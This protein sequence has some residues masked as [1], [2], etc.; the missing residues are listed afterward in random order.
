MTSHA[1]SQRITQRFLLVSALLAC[2]LLGACAPTAT[3]TASQTGITMP[4]TV[5]IVAQA[6]A[7]GQRVRFWATPE[8][9]AMWQVLIDNGVAQINTDDLSGLRT[10]LL[11][12]DH[13]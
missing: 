5:Q 7:G 12:H 4:A 11:Q 3:N 6:H 8:T 9:P 10:Y 2:T 1:Y 13:Q